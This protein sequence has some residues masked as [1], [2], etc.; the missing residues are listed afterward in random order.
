MSN[1]RNS[2]EK[3]ETVRLNVQYFGIDG[4]VSDADETPSIEI[5]S[6]DGSVII[7]KTTEGV[8]RSD[9]GFYYYDYYVNS[10]ADTGMWQDTWSAQIQGVSIEDSFNFLV[11]SPA[12]VEI[13]SVRIGDEVSFDFSEEELNG[14]NILLK[15]L[16]AR[17]RSD[18]KKPKRDQFGAFVRDENGE[19]IYIE[20]NVFSDELLV[21]FLCQALSEF[22]MIPFFTTFSFADRII[23][24]TF[25]QIVVEA[26]MV[27]ALASQALVEKGRDFTISDGGVSYQPPALGDFLASQYN[28][29]L[30][31]YRERVKFIKNSIRP[32]PKGFG[33]YTNLTSGSPAFARLRHLRQRRII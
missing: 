18:G 26:A 8:I 28:N 1:N 17:L 33:T 9:E 6:V 14:I 7:S 3:G 11:I 13:G 4:A 22:N 21:C 5:K 29:F 10:D 12:S 30:S 15:Y 31:N 16:K 24:T 27:F 23:Y 2:A 32:G 25:S 20:C 19:I